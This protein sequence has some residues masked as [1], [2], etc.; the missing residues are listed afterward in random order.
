MPLKLNY[1]KEN[2]ITILHFISWNRLGRISNKISHFHL[3]RVYLSTLFLKAF[4]LML[5]PL[6]QNQ[7]DCS[8][9]SITLLEWKNI[10]DD[11]TEHIRNKINTENGKTFHCW[12]IIAVISIQRNR[13]VSICTDAFYP[14]S[15]FTLQSPLPLTLQVR[16]TKTSDRMQSS[17][18]ADGRM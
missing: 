13:S 15:V 14:T 4:M 6:S 10:Y 3:P 18:A 9:L 16:S 2:K 17:C 8:I 5:L 7:Q 12:R 1:T 11:Y